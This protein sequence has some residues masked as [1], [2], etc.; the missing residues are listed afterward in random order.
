VIVKRN[1]RASAHARMRAG[2]VAVVLAVG[3]GLSGCVAGSVDITAETGE[4]LQSTVLAVA[5]QAAAGDS[6][7]ALATL[8]ALQARLDE[9]V[10]AGDVSAERAAAIQ[11][12]I[13]LVRADLQ[14]V[15]TPEPVPEPEP[16]APV[17]VTETAAPA[18]TEGDDDG[19]DGDDADDET[20][21]NGNGNSGNGNG[22]SGNGNGNKNKDK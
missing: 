14:P 6:A 12:A 16:A 22:N 18:P 17:E 4:Q 19:D 2:A 13:D 3:L 11:Q 1:A 15:T 10:A 8:D 20:P 5:D 9:A 21:G 7:G